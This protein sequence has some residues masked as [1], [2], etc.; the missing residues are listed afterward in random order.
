MIKHVGMVCPNCGDGQKITDA[1]AGELICAKC[2]FVIRERIG[3]EG[4]DWSVAAREGQPIEDEPDFTCPLCHGS[5]QS[6]GCP[7][8]APAVGL[9]LPCDPPLTDS[10][11]GISG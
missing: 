1:E 7:V 2:G 6:S 9:M 5:L 4:G 10:E 3:S 11:H 8:G